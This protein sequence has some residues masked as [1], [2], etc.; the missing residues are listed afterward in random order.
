VSDRKM[1]EVFLKQMMELFVEPEIKRRRASGQLPDDWQLKGAQVVFFDD[2][3]AEIRLNDEI[4]ALLEVKVNR[5]IQ[6]GD[7]VF[8]NM[9]DEFRSMRLPDTEDP[10]CAHATFLKVENQ[11]FIFFDFRYNRS[12]AREHLELAREYLDS[13]NDALLRQHIPVLVEN[14]LAAS[15]LA[16]K[17]FL[18][19]FPDPNIRTSK[20][21]KVVSSHLNLHA[22]LGNLDDTA[23]SAFNKL[24]QMRSAARYAGE[25][26]MPKIDEAKD[27]LR[28][29]EGLVSFVERKVNG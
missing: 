24:W 22:K 13:A 1:A 10:N 23:I 9:I 27:L 5:A 14:L 21:H 2:R 8:W 25:G 12:H 3:V 16:G 26:S 15:E 17:A 20:S 18:L 6:A 19:L 4:Q 28:R 29:V 11:W 7:P